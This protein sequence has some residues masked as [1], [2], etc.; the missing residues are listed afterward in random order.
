MQPIVLFL[1]KIKVCLSIDKFIVIL[2]FILHLLK[3]QHAEN[4]IISNTES[5]NYL[6]LSFFII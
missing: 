5:R 3:I 6:R 1:T 2:L 4:K